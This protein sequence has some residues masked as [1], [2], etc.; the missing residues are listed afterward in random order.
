M[1]PGPDRVNQVVFR[2]SGV[3]PL[4]PQ[5]QRN[6]GHC[7]ASHLRHVWTA[8]SWQ[9]KTLRRSVGRCSHVFGL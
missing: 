1:T 8:P 6:L 5:R 2:L 7:V 3:S 4:V 9:G